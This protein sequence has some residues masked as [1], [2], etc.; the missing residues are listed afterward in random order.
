MKIRPCI[1]IH[2]GKVKQIVGSTLSDTGANMLTENFVSEK[3]PGYYAL[4]FKKHGLTGGHIIMLGP[5]NEKAALEALSAWPGGMQIGG[6]INLE[7]ARYWINRGASHVIVT[8]L[9]FHNGRIDMERLTALTNIVGKNRL[10]LD[11]SCRKMDGRYLVVTDRWQNFTEEE[12]TGEA[13]HRLSG[14]CSEFLVHGVDV[15]GRCRG[16]DSE[17]V[18]ML[19]EMSPIPTTYAGGARS[20]DDAFKVRE[21]GKGRIDLTIGSALDIFGGTGVLFEEIVR[22]NRESAR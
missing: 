6:G 7:N 1:D 22:F 13:L 8:S 17:L 16:V 4:L 10:V 9:V 5:G 12:I 19:G 11:L 3:S 2:G 18:E 21:K 14:Y 15:E 20:I